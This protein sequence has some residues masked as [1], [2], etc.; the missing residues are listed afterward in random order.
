MFSRLLVVKKHAIKAASV[1][2]ASALFSS[3][4]LLGA[5]LVSSAAL[6]STALAANTST[7]DDSAL[8]KFQ[9]K[10]QGMESFQ[11]H[12]VQVSKAQ[13]GVI[14]Q[15]LEGDLS[16]A[17]AGR[18]RWET[19]DPYAQLVV[20]DGK[21][22]WIYD[23]DIEQVTIRNMEQ[24]IQDTPA[25]LLSGNS[26]QIDQ[27]FVVSQQGSDTDPVFKLVP[28]DPSQLFEALEFHYQGDTLSSML[29]FDAAGSITEI[30]FSQQQRNR[31]IDSHAFVFDVPEG[32]DVIDG[33]QAL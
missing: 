15:Q 14:Q 22:I 26:D 32:V 7:K 20:A 4:M 3:A 8:S 5:A 29:I 24:R 1:F 28:K 21:L 33:R 23:M 19:A 12:F 25:L 16:V 31:D 17:K 2:S 18:M 9:S 10:L 6:T 11:A 13:S 27:S 30:S